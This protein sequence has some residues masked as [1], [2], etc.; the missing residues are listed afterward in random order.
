MLVKLLP[1]GVTAVQIFVTVNG[2]YRVSLVRAFTL[3][4]YAVRKIRVIFRA[5]TLVPTNLELEDRLRNL[6]RKI[7]SCVR[8]VG[9]AGE[10]NFAGNDSDSICGVVIGLYA[11]CCWSFERL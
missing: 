4:L 7:Y 6:V 2:I 5:V 3:K 9:M 11:F 1:Y 10:E 8:Y